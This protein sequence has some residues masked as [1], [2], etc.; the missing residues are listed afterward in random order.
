[1][2]PTLSHIVSVKRVY[3]TLIQ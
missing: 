3:L 2:K 1:M